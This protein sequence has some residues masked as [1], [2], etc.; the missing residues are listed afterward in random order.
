MQNDESQRLWAVEMKIWRTI[1]ESTERQRKYV[2]SALGEKRKTI[3]FFLLEF[4][5]EEE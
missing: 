5:Q 1:K 2:P 3:F 4:Q